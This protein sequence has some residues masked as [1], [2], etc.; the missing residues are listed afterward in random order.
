VNWFYSGRAS[1]FGETIIYVPITK[2]RLDQN[3]KRLEDSHRRSTGDKVPLIIPPL[4]DKTP[5]LEHESIRNTWALAG[6]ALRN[7]DCVYCIGYSL[8]PTDIAIQMLLRANVR[9]TIPF[10]VVNLDSDCS[11][12]YR[13]LFHGCPFKVEGKYV[14][15]N[16][17]PELV[18]SLV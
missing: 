16:A 12:H 7:A 13:K 10:I 17:L 14:G 11:S 6:A 9:K 15:K 5:Y 4:F 3:L 8:P 2:W 18:Q 1:F